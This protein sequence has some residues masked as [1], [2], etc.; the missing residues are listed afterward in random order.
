MCV[1]YLTS[2]SRYYWGKKKKKKKQKCSENVTEW[3]VRTQWCWQNC[4]KLYFLPC[5][6]RCS[7]H[8]ILLNPQQQSGRDAIHDYP[9]VFVIPRKQIKSTVLK[10]LKPPSTKIF[11]GSIAISFV[12]MPRIRCFKKYCNCDVSN[13]HTR[14]C[15][16]YD[17]FHSVRLFIPYLWKQSTNDLET[18][19][20]GCT[21]I[22]V[23]ALLRYCPSYFCIHA[24]VSI[25]D[26]KNIYNTGGQME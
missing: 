26:C 14:R 3:Y 1:L 7:T 5:R 18:S 2:S 12:D 13:M 8:L 19:F 25:R 23:T 11:I 16:H 22:P 4:L 10:P 17:V 20:I 24:P 21:W 9:T 6:L 15:T